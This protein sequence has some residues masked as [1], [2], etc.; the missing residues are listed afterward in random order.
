VLLE[1]GQN[2]AFAR[3]NTVLHLTVMALKIISGVLFPSIGERSIGS[4]RISFKNGDLLPDAGAR[5][6][7]GNVIGSGAYIGK[8]CVQVSLRH[9]IFSDSPQRGVLSAFFDPS[10]DAS[11]NL[12]DDLIIENG[13]STGVTISWT[14]TPRE[15][16][17][18]MK[19]EI[20]EISVL[21]IGETA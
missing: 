21:I 1:P 8:P 14:A 17:A 11:F 9:I 12:N 7:K 16:G 6:S 5:F 13:V 2:A 3:P 4:A 18:Q 10:K 19:S 20:M 15:E